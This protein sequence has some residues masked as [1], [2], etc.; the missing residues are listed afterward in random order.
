[1]K[2]EVEL[3]ALEVV[4]M[5]LRQ[6]LDVIEEALEPGGRPLLVLL[7]EMARELPRD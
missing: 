1:V 6:L 4:L 2:A 5:E 7:G 3:P